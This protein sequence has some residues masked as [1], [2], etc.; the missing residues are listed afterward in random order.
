MNE[1]EIENIDIV[2]DPPDVIQNVLKKLIKKERELI[3]M[4]ENYTKE[5][6]KTECDHEWEFRDPEKIGHEMVFCKKCGYLRDSKSTRIIC[7]EDVCTYGEPV[8]YCERY[9]CKCYNYEKLLF[10]GKKMNKQINKIMIQ[11]EDIEKKN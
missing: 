6:E 7:K 10:E 3:K 9:N 4:S 1:K 11:I 2:N 8:E 5:D